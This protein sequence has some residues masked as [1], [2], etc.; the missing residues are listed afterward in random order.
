MT[1]EEPQP[2]KCGARVTDKVGIEIHA[3]GFDG[4]LTDE[5]RLEQVIV[6]NGAVVGH[7]EPEYIDVIKHLR[8]GFDLIAVDLAPPDADGPVGEDQY[9]RVEV[10]DDDPYVTN[11]DLVLQGYCE[12]WPMEDRRRCYVHTG[13]SQDKEKAK[14]HGVENITHGM[15]AKRSKFYQ[16]LDEQ[17]KLFVE[18]LVDSWIDNAPFDRDNFAKVNELFRIAIDEIRAWRAQGE[19]ADD[20]DGAGGMLTDVTIDYD[21]ENGEITTEDENPLNLA[22]DRLDRTKYKKLKELGVLDDPDSQEAEAKQS[23]ADVFDNLNE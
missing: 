8:K 19:Y 22:Y 12:R 15:R 6:E 4:P 2:E 3:D 14:S 13:Q 23:L 1:T 20:D 7:K 17:D 11:R 10:D 16:S 5:G 21:P 9:Q 18:K